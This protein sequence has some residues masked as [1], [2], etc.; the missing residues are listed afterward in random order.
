MGKIAL[1]PGLGCLPQVGAWPGTGMEWPLPVRTRADWPDERL[2]SQKKSILGESRFP[3]IFPFQ[4][5]HFGTLRA[6]IDKKT[7]KSTK[8]IKGLLQ[9]GIAP[10]PNR[11]KICV[12]HF[13]RVSGGP[14]GAPSQERTHLRGSSRGMCRPR[15]ATT[16]PQPEKAYHRT[17]MPQR[18]ETCAG[19][20]GNLPYISHGSVRKTPDLP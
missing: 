12:T 11:N 2:K 4:S 9:K 7:A 3:Y 15:L 19:Q 17:G 14:D 20:F 16:L 1:G 10:Q 6:K 5:H 13:F 8:S 18:E